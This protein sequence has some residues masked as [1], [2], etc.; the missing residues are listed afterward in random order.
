MYLEFYGLFV[1]L[2]KRIVLIQKENVCESEMEH[3][4]GNRVCTPVVELHPRTIAKLWIRS[5]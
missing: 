3:P 1:H 5:T 4:V 2:E